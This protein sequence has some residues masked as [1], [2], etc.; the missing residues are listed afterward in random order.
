MQKKSRRAEELS[1]LNAIACLM[2]IF[3]HVAS[4]GIVNATPDSWQAAVIYFPWRLA[5]CVV[6]TFLFSS[7]VKMAFQYEEHYTFRSYTGYMLGRVRN[8]YLPYALWCLVYYAVYLLLGYYAFSPV[9][10][11]K[12]HFA[13]TMSAPFYYIVIAMQFYLLKPLWLWVMKNLRWYTAIPISV[14]VTFLSMY[15]NSFLGIWGV[16]FPYTDRIFTTYLVFWIAGLYAGRHWDKLTESIAGAGKNV[17]VSV[18]AVLLVTLIPYFQHAKGVWLVDTSYYKVFTDLLSIFILLWISLKLRTAAAPMKKFL[19]FVSAASF[20]VYLSHCLFLTVAEHF[21]ALAG[22]TKL[23]VVLVI[24]FLVCY[25]IP[26]PLYVLL[27]RLRT[28]V[29]GHSAKKTA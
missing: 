24:R 4:Y 3:I 17:A 8:I 16:S 2:V 22:L 5:A 29:S 19:S 14:L 27:N 26:F 10:F 12:M 15:L 28:I 20:S 21:M 25:G 6:P 23:S 11:L 13:G 7:A 9:H 18:G 1:Y